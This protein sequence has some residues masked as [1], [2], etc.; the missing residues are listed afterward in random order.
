MNGRRA[1]E[2]F[3]G[4]RKG[5]LAFEAKEIDELIKLELV[6]EGDPRDLALIQQ[7]DP[8]V[9][10]YTGTTF[11]DPE[12]PQKVAARLAEV[13]D[14]LKSSWSRL[15]TRDSKVQAQEAERKQLRRALAVLNDQTTRGRL[16]TLGR[17][18]LAT[19]WFACPP[20]GDEVYAL[21]HKGAR[22]HQQLALRVERYAEH[23]LSA[24]M[25]GFDKTA[26]KM[27]SFGGEIATLSKNIG[28]VKKNPHQ[29]VIGLAKT[30]MPAT[31]ALGVYTA[32]LR[33]VA[34]DVAVTY[35]RNADTYGGAQAVADRIRAAQRALRQ[36]GF[37]ESPEVM[38]AAKTLLPY[39]SVE[40]GAQRFLAIFNGVMGSGLT[41][42]QLAPTVKCTARL[43]PA[44]GTP[45]EVV[46]RLVAAAHGLQ[47]RP[48]GYPQIHGGMLAAALASM[49]RDISQVEDL[50]ERFRQVEL[51]LMMAKVCNVTTVNEIALECVTAPGTPTEVADTV[52]ALAHEVATKS[53]RAQPNAADVAVAASFA[54]RFAF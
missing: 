23:P 28:Y 36:L 43:M 8:V 6:I 35:A 49:V 13:E 15:T 31:Q 34:P 33:G 50:V 19:L 12:A 14:K 47:R 42:G 32:N 44:D 18:P 40:A 1:L 38:G 5:Q 16:L 17:A 54:K 29:V 10:Q 4:F 22:V 25:K 27:A 11:A 26:A 39:P 46:Q 51:A 53:E 20:L 30:G 2:I 37:I 7:V 52:S 24:F 21:T 9:Q 45:A 48:V 41:N 3:D